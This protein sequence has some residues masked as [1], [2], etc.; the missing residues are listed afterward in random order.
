[1][2]GVM[3]FFRYFVFRIL[4]LTAMDGLFSTRDIIRIK[5]EPYTMPQ[6]TF[7]AFICKS[8]VA[9][10][11]IGEKV[12][13]VEQNVVCIFVPFTVVRVLDYS[14][15]WDGVM[16]EAAFDFVM[17]TIAGI[18]V[19][20]RQAVRSMP[21]VSTS[22]SQC[23]KLW[24]LIGI[25]GQRDRELAQ[26]DANRKDGSIKYDVIARLTQA[27][28]L[29]IL[30]VY[31]A[32]TPIDDL[33]LSKGAQMYNRFIVS[34]FA[35]CHRERNVAFYA[36]EQHLSPG[37]FSVI[38]KAQSGQTALKWIEEVTMVKIRH[39]LRQPELSVKAIAIRMNF[40]DQSS[41]GRYFK[42]FEGM[43]PLA[44]RKRMA[45]NESD[46]GQHKHRE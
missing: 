35:H 18:P 12:Y 30:D 20:K 6:A 24:Q 44:Y 32:C 17:A 5:S 9:R 25:I 26:D 29:E 40:P 16:V 8:G 2:R 4:K 14:R 43:S 42:S 36:R 3:D 7:G 23:D 45:E 10:V 31:F 27:L 46:Y 38:I 39:L 21:C 28:M 15:D 37:H 33:P 22:Q 34:V 19:L 1:M 13:R 11:S 41:F